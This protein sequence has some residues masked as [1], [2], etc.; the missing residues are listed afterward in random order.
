[1]STIGKVIEFLQISL[2]APAILAVILDF[3]LRWKT[4]FLLMSI[5]C[6]K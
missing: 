6:E 5:V 3:K 1:M 2:M 4:N